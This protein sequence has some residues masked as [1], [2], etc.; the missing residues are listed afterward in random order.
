MTLPSKTDLQT[1]DYT[2]RGLPF[3]WVE[4]TPLNTQSLDITW[5]GL[6]FVA[7]AADTTEVVPSARLWPQQLRKRRKLMKA[8]QRLI[9]Q[10][11]EDK[12]LE[13]ETFEN[14]YV[15]TLKRDI[16]QV[17]EEANRRRAEID[18]AKRQLAATKSNKQSVIAAEMAVQ[19]ATEALFEVTLL[20]DELEQEMLDMDMAYI[21]LIVIGI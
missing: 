20:R 17:K 16:E 18:R 12:Q 6:P 8:E 19:A 9:P 1:L 11:S 4:A 7:A 14:L 13:V 2:W 15:E 10:E 21:M 3:C 5:R